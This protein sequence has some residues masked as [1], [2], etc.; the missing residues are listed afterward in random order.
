MGIEK[1][2]ERVVGVALVGLA[3]KGIFDH[4]SYNQIKIESFYTCIL[5]KGNA[6]LG[7]EIT[8]TSMR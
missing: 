5:S 1:R 6:G 7:V 8:K 4:L 3:V 2:G